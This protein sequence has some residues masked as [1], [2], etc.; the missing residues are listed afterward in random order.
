VKLEI[1]DGLTILNKGFLVERLNRETGES[2]VYMQKDAITNHED[3]YIIKGIG[4][5]DEPY[6]YFAHGIGMVGM[7]SAD[8]IEF[9]VREETIYL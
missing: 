3:R 4:K 2:E 6:Q 9:S 5:Y 1:K 8:D 7:S